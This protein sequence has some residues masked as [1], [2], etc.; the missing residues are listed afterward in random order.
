MHAAI[1]LSFVRRLK[2][3]LVALKDLII[4]VPQN[5]NDQ[6]RQKVNDVI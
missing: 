6:L 5:I 3:Y 2:D 4:P 1:L